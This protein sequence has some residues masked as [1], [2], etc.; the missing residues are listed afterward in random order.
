MEEFLQMRN[1]L[2][3]FYVLIFAAIPIILFFLLK[4]SIRNIVAFLQIR[5]STNYQFVNTFEFEG[6]PKCRIFNIGMQSTI[7]QDITKE[8]M[9]FIPNCEFRKMRIWLNTEAIKINSDKKNT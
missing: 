7:I 1:V 5:M 2:Q 6:R 4:D 3:A 8:Q 9:M